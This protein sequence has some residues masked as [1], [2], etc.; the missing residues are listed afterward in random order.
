LTG[1]LAEKV[2]KIGIFMGN[3]LQIRDHGEWN[4][5]L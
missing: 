3:I 1:F 2:D 4:S 5:F